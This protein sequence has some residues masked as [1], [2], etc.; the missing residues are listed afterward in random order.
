MAE[1]KA[2]QDPTRTRTSTTLVEVVAMEEEGWAALL[3]EEVPARE[4][5]GAA[6]PEQ[7]GLPQLGDRHHRQRAHP[8][9]L[10]PESVAGLHQMTRTT[11][12][13]SQSWSAANRASTNQYRP[14]RCARPFGAKGQGLAQQD[15][16]RS[17][18]RRTAVP[19]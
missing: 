2:G 6:E 13:V 19:L 10:R 3:A 9:D 1:I 18:G 8:H 11:T 14:C 7:V 5:S 12:L 16:G 15:A 17:C 4:G